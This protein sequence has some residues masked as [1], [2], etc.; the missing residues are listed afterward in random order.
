MSAWA[1]ETGAV[2]LEPV[3]VHWSRTSGPV[4]LNTAPS[5]PFSVVRWRV[6]GAVTLAWVTSAPAAKANEESAMTLGRAERS[7]AR[8][9]IS[10]PLA[11]QPRIC[12]PSALTQSIPEPAR[13]GFPMTRTS[14]SVRS[15]IL[16][17][18]TNHEKAC[19]RTVIR[20]ALPPQAAPELANVIRPELPV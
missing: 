8:E 2:S 4:P 5:T 6:S 12:T 10:G 11:V 13:D 14:S 19:R 7:E 15:V 18:A 3:S 20:L 16:T 1:S 9:T 17:R